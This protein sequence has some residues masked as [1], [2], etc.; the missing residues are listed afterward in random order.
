MIQIIKQKA[1]ILYILAVA[2]SVASISGH[3]QET[4]SSKPVLLMLLLDSSDVATIEESLKHELQLEIESHR[5]E[6]SE[7]FAFKSNSLTERILE[8]RGV[9]DN[10]HA[11]AVIWLEKVNPD[12]VALQLV[13]V[14]PGRS[15]V[16][17]IETKIGSETKGELAIAIKE[18]LNDIYIPMRE[19][20]EKLP[21]SGQENKKPQ[22]TPSSNKKN[23]PQLTMTLDVSGDFKRTDQSP[24]LLG[25]MVALGVQY[26]CGFFWDINFSLFGAPSPGINNGTF[27]TIGIRPGVGI[28]FLWNHKI[29]SVGPQLGLQ[30]PWQQAD[31]TINNNESTK[32]SWWDFRFTPG[33]QMKFRLHQNFFFLL[34]GGAGIHVNQKVFKQK[35][36][37]AIIYSSPY[38]DWNCTVG[39]VLYFS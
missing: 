24:L 39:I 14:S 12:T 1:F 8:I 28:G 17:S 26:P 15:T 34:R 18:L 16:R 37:N 4:D 32:E 13:V 33:L 35:S 31:A 21:T 22:T 3:A 23:I 25:G 5:I 27:R 19:Q 2:F 20:P 10:F 29:I 6:T 38:F 9:A 7:N 36:D 30:I 11:D